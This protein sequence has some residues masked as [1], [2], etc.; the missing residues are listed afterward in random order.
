MRTKWFR[1]LKVGTPIFLAILG[2]FLFKSSSQPIRAQNWKNYPFNKG[3]INF[4]QDEGGHPA[5]DTEWWYVN[6]HARGSDGKDY[7]GVITFAR[8]SFFGSAV[9]GLLLE[10][11]NESDKKFFY[12][13]EVGVIQAEVGKLKTYFVNSLGTRS[14]LIQKDNSPFQYDLEVE[15]KTNGP[16]VKYS[17]HLD[18]LKIPLTEGED[19]LVPIGGGISSY[20]YSLTRLALTGTIKVGEEIITL[21]NGLAWFDHQ[22]FSAAGANVKANH[23]WFSLQLEDGYDLVYWRIFKD[24]NQTPETSYLGVLDA[25]GR[26]FDD[27]TLGN[28]LEVLAWWEAQKL[29]KKWRLETPNFAG[30]RS[31]LWET[32]V[33]DQLVV[34]AAGNVYEG[35]VKVEQ[36][37]PGQV[38]GK[39]YAELTHQY[40]NLF[41]MPQGLVY[42]TEAASL[43]G[44]HP[45]P[46]EFLEALGRKCGFYPLALSLGPERGW[47][48]F[49][50]LPGPDLPLNLVG[51]AFLKMPR[52]CVS[53][54]TD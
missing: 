19:G 48:S 28:D 30:L 50:W 14:S 10:L 43:I 21:S 29:G 16:Q 35:S 51:G 37:S 5:Y 18:S 52:L 15:G 3:Q 54:D 47:Q 4:P 53:E 23:E 27:A 36:L 9:G 7:A 32:T 49:I 2:L 8:T 41:R 11:T 22:W 24:D 17:F 34:S 33:E 42:W 31:L 44:P 39:G 25:A 38:S 6:F 12:D 20:Y 1:P 45:T 13:T 40:Q 46:G 26:Q